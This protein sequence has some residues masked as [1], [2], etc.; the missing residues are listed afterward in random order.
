MHLRE[1]L[2]LVERHHVNIA[3]ADHL[4]CKL[5]LISTEAELGN[6]PEAARLSEEALADV[7]PAM[8]DSALLAET[9]WTASTVH[10]LQGDHGGA[11][12]LILDALAVVD[13]R[14]D[15]T[16]WMRLRLVAAARAMQE[17]TPCLAE[18][19]SFLES[20][21]PVLKLT[22]SPRQPWRKCSRLGWLR[23]FWTTS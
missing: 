18:A 5:V 9:Y 4:R 11:F 13:S 21:E 19:Q 12:A 10:A 22:G 2:D 7:D 17:P 16:L 6:L 1:A 23:T 14:E 20:V 15:L 8:H 3:A